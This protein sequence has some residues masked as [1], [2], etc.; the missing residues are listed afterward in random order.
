MSFP[1]QAE[2]FQIDSADKCT[3]FTKRHFPLKPFGDHDVDIKVEACGVCGSDIHTITGG[4]GEQ[5][6]PLCVGH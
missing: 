4:W 5:H 1:D 3:E 6:F 2:G